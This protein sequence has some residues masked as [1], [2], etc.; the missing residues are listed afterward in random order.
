MN[1]EVPMR[2]STA[3]FG[4]ID[5]VG[6]A[7]GQAPLALRL[8]EQSME[9]RGADLEE[10]VL[11]SLATVRLQDQPL[12]D[13]FLEEHRNL[14]RLR[15]RV[16]GVE[17]TFHEEDMPTLLDGLTVQLILTSDY[18]RGRVCDAFRRAGGGAQR[19]AIPGADPGMGARRVQPDG[20]AITPLSEDGLAAFI[21]WLRHPRRTHSSLLACP[22][23]NR[24]G[25]MV[26]Q[27]RGILVERLATQFQ[28][29]LFCFSYVFG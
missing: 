22:A 1:S 4:A 9:I 13:A 25:A 6:F 11:K 16:E 29:Q 20:S 12:V 18:F 7:Y 5:S 24:A 21:A 28:G 2:R 8:L 17:P 15:P 27:P 3:L 19:H 14:M 26:F 10:R 23:R